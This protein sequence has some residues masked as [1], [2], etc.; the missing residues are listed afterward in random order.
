MRNTIEYKKSEPYNLLSI[1]IVARLSVVFA[2]HVA[3]GV[4]KA[5]SYECEGTKFCKKILVG[6]PMFVVLG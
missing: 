4:S 3:A 2:R 6:L 5:R 1:S